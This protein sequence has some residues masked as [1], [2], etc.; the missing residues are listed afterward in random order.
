MAK[1]VPG[2]YEAAIKRYEETT[3]E[4]L[5]SLPVAK[6][7]SVDGLVEAINL[8]NKDFEIF[9]QKRHGVFAAL[10]TAMRPIEQWGDLAFG[11]AEMAFPPS[12][13]VFGSVLNL[14]SAAKNVSADYDAIEQLMKR[15]K[16]TRVS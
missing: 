8:T 9:R 16:V 5:Y 2:I 11:A 15:L 1:P 7:S 13:L 10:S 14:V 6:L 12:S 4:N 3:K